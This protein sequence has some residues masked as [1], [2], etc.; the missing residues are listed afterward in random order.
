MKDNQ[1]SASKKSEIGETENC[2]ENIIHEDFHTWVSRTGGHNGGWSAEDHLYMVTLTHRHAN[3]RRLPDRFL[4]EIWSGVR[5]VSNR[6]AVKR[7]VEWYAE[8][9]VRRDRQKMKIGKWRERRAAVKEQ[10]RKQHSATGTKLHK[11]SKPGWLHK[12]K[13]K[14]KKL[15]EWKKLKTVK[16]EIEEAEELLRVAE[17]KSKIEQRMDRRN[18]QIKRYLKVR[19]EKK[20]MQLRQEEE[21]KRIK[22]LERKHRREMNR[23]VLSQYHEKD[24]ERIQW[25]VKQKADEQVNIKKK[26][27]LMSSIFS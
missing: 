23:M 3:W 19:E 26:Y 15:E 16:K 20:K 4:E 7:H 13:E 6:E 21:E 22:E 18:T 25:K 27:F 5:A 8:Y 2:D 12:N 17:K 11:T 9:C 1:D 14:L 24:M 10:E